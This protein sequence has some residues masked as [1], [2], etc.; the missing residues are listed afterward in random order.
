MIL[1]GVT[2]VLFSVIVSTSLSV[3]IKTVE[4]VCVSS[5][6]GIIKD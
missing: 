1:L 2:C 5:C 4:F 3:Y 6:R